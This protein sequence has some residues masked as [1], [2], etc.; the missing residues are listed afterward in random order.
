MAISN[1]EISDNERT[2]Y[3]IENFDLTTSPC[4]EAFIK[5]RNCDPLSSFGDFIAISGEVDEPCARLIAREVSDGIIAGGY[6]E[7]ALEIL[8]KKKMV[9]L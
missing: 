5:A 7:I 2:I 6:S 3:D 4:G 8:R 1:G 9:S